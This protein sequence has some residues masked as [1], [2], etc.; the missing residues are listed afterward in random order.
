MMDVDDPAR[1]PGAERLGKHLHVASQD[2]QFHIIGPDEIEQGGFR[3]SL[4]IRAHLQAEERYAIAFYQ[5][6]ESVVVR[7]DT[8][9]I[10]R[11]GPNAVTIK[12][13][14]ET[15]AYFGHHDQDFWTAPRVPNGQVHVEALHDRPQFLNKFGFPT[16]LIGSIERDPLKEALRVGI[17]ELRAF[18]DVAI[19][20]RQLRRNRGNDARAAGAG[21]GHEEVLL[22]RTHLHSRARVQGKAASGDVDD[23]RVVAE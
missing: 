10:Y 1:H 22:V 9:D 19:A 18:D 8:D 14:I 5:G 3:L 7:S 6:P 13:V 21:D 2:H 20:V 16:D 11:Q 12:Q 23:R 17:D 4:A 15:V